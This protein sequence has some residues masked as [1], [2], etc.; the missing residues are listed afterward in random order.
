MQHAGVML[1]EV[2]D[3]V[4]EPDDLLLMEVAFVPALSV[5]PSLSL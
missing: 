5:W 3:D 2:N 4:G 1:G